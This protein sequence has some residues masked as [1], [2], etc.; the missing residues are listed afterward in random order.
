MV[1]TMC[2]S[3]DPHDETKPD[4]AALVMYVQT[5]APCKVLAVQCELVRDD[6]GGVDKHIDYVYY[7]PTEYED[8]KV[9]WGGFNP[10]TGLRVGLPSISRRVKE[11]C[12]CG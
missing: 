7:Y 8:G 11:D 3:G 6:W 9:M 1:L 4:I 10:K 5:A 12:G 2:A